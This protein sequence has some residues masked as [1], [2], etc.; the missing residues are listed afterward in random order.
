MVH[1][2]R[3]SKLR[4]NSDISKSKTL[5]RKGSLSD[6]VTLLSL[7]LS[8]VSLRV[9]SS[10]FKT[11]IKTVI[12]PLTYYKTANAGELGTHWDKTNKELRPLIMVIGFVLFS[13]CVSIWAYLQPEDVW[14]ANYKMFHRRYSCM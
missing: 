10:Y 11:I 8:H 4:R 9:N 14:N 6:T 3:I 7:K 1:V 13:Q 5:P 12:G 2:L